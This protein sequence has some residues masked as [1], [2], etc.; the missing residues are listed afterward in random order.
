LGSGN[1]EKKTKQ[2]VYS[3]TVVACST[4]ISLVDSAVANVKSTETTIGDLYWDPTDL[5]SA[6]DLLNSCDDSGIFSSSRYT[7]NKGV[8]DAISDWYNWTLKNDQYSKTFGQVYGASCP[9]DEYINSQSDAPVEVPLSTT[10]SQSLARTSTL[11]SALFAL[12]I[13]ALSTILNW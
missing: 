4:A 2:N 6:C 10:T 9:D 12:G 8:C 7:Y 11:S 3:S 1:D 13:V 5:L